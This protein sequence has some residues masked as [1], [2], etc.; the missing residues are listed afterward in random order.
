MWVVSDRRFSLMTTISHVLPHNQPHA[1]VR[2]TFGRQVKEDEFEQFKKDVLQTY[3]DSDIKLNEKDIKREYCFTRKK[4]PIPIIG[5]LV[6]EWQA[7][8]DR[9]KAGENIDESI[10][11][12]GDNVLILEKTERLLPYFGLS[13]WWY[14]NLNKDLK[15]KQADKDNL[16]LENPTGVIFSLL[17]QITKP[18]QKFTADL[19]NDNL[20]AEYRFDPE[21]KNQRY[22]A[23]EFTLKEKPEELQS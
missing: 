7:A 9:A 2:S 3:A 19:F 14:N 23:T 1:T 6:L 16:T 12:E 20:T 22:L 4:L 18:L 21:K 15:K 17:E 5:W 11:K 13:K 10:A 8:K